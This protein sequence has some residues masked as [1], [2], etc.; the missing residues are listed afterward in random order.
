LDEELVNTLPMS[1]RFSCH[2]GQ[3]KSK[4]TALKR[5]HHSA[6]NLLLGAGYDQID[7]KA[8]TARSILVSNTPSAVDDAT[9]DVAVFLLLGALRNFNQAIFSLRNNGWL[10]ATPA[11]TD[12]QGKFLGIL[13]MGES[14]RHWHE[15]PKPWG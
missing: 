4:A 2:N 9:A 15:E 7:V 8:C 1:V 13:G 12:P 3:Y 10:G 11:G 14:E 6:V 5:L